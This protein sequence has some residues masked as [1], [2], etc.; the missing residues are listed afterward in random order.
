MRLPFWCLYSSHNV[1][2]F[3]N[4]AWW[5]SQDKRKSSKLLKTSFFYVGIFLCQRDTEGR[6]IE[7]IIRKTVIGYP[8]GYC[9]LFVCL[10]RDDLQWASFFSFTRFLDHTQR[11]TTVGRTPWTSDQLVVETTTWQHTSFTTDKYPCHR[12]DS[13]PQSKKAS[14]WRTTP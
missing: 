11:H 5:S 12:W 1:N 7:K 4:A 2:C 13:N 10:W 14:G 6:V 8:K 9:K 3:I